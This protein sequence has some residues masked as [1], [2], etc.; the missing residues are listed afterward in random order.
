ML[1][2]RDELAEHARRELRREDR[3]RRLVAREGAGRD[4]PLVG[5]ALGADLVGGLAE[6]ERLRLREEVRE[7][8]GVDVLAWLHGLPVA[9]LVLQRTS[10]L[11]DRDEVR[12]DEP[13]A[14][15][16]ELVERVLAVRAR[17]APEDLARV[18]RDRRSVPADA[19]AVRLHRELLQVRGEAVQVLRVGQHR[20]ALRAE[21]VRVPDVEQAHEDGDVLLE[22]RG[23]D[24]LVDRVEAREELLPVLL[25]DGDDD[26]RADGRVDRVAAAHPVPEAEGVL[27]VDAERGDLVE[28]G[29]DG[30]E[31]LRDGVRLLVVARV[32]QAELRPQPLACQARVRQGLEGAE[33]LRRDDEE[34]GLGVE[35]GGLLVDV[36][37]VDVRDEARLEPGLHVGLEGLVDHD[38]AEVRATDAD[39]DDGLDALARD[40]RPLTG[41]DLLG[42]GVDL[43]ERG[44]HVGVD[45]LA[46]DDERRLDALGTTE[47]GVQHGAVLGDV[48]VLTGEHRLEALGDT[49]VLRDLEQRGEDVVVDEALRQVHGQVGGL[50]RVALGTAGVA[51]EPTAQVGGESVGDAGELLPAVGRCG[52]DGSGFG[53][54]GPPGYLLDVLDRGSP[55][56]CVADHVRA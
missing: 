47:R 10:G 13:R 17:L 48:D 27:R 18:G 29:R 41:A 21:E 11:R 24:V 51:V 43:V 50:E 15:V 39:V 34:R 16:D 55:Q 38:R 3:R 49:G 52:V 37:G 23:A 45:V 6:R 19:L 33:G 26:A 4:D 7:E 12:G 2:E 25:A 44:V 9:G 40:T 1:V 32:G 22:R 20:V 46:V 28:R 56:R 30:D 36:R 8:E 53:H 54:F 31:V 5:G 14:L 42:E 35:V